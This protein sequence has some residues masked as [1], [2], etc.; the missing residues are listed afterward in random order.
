M[1][2]QIITRT[3]E[4]SLHEV[5]PTKILKVINT[6]IDSL[7]SAVVNNFSQNS[8][9]GLKMLLLIWLVKFHGRQFI[10]ESKALTI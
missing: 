6:L 3:Y 2:E 8:V 4:G 10:T 1:D 9:I 5:K 7:I